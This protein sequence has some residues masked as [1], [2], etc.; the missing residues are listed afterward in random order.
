MSDLSDAIVNCTHHADERFYLWFLRKKKK[1]YLTSTI[2]ITYKQLWWAGSLRTDRQTDW[3]PP[4]GAK[5]SK[6]NHHWAT[7]MQAKVQRKQATANCYDS[8]S[9]SVMSAH[10]GAWNNTLG[11]GQKCL[12]GSTAQESPSFENWRMFWH[13]SKN[14]T[15]TFLKSVFISQCHKSDHTNKINSHL[16]S[17]ILLH[18]AMILPP[19][20]FTHIWFVL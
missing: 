2:W 14:W 8:E 17:I 9:T 1:Q 15:N 7:F 18:D 13:W 12:P 11:S 20:A 4:K 19:Y 16:H 5:R 6:Q 10:I 3:L